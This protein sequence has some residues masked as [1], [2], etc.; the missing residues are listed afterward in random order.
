MLWQVIFQ[1]HLMV[2]HARV[3]W[4]VNISAEMPD[5]CPDVK[6]ADIR[7]IPHAMHAVRSGVQRI[8]ALS[9]DTDV[10]VL[11]MLYWGILHSEG[12][13]E[14]WIRACV[15][16]TRYIPVHIL[17]PRIGQELCY[18]LPLVHTLTG[19]DYTS[20][21]RTNYAALNANPSEY[22]R[23]FDSGPSCTDVFV[24]SCEAYLV[25][26]LKWNTTCATMDQVR[27][28]IY[29]H[30]KGVSWDQ[31][32][33]RSHAKEQHILRAYYATYQMATLLLHRHSPKV[34]NPTVFG[35]KKT[36]EIF[37]PIK[38]LRPI[39]EEYT[40]LC[41]CKKCSKNSCACRKAGLLCISFCKC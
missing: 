17:A 6:E 10:F 11:L 1:V 16:D 14:F 12:L 31:L 27:N 9:G 23:N 24:A 20:K 2:L 5:L 18:L 37:L 33:P 39:P 25:Q 22:L 26:V 21:V 29:H 13:K 36:D 30:S 38:G 3:S 15:G 35:F 32:P 34:L 28:Y 41:N 4:M 8:V 40:S 19:C 7:I